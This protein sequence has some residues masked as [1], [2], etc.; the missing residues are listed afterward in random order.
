M[1][2]RLEEMSN[3]ELWRLFPII[4][5]PHNPLWRENYLRE[6]E[7]IEKAIGRDNI[8]RIHHYGST[9]IPGLLAK[10]TIDILLEVKDNT[11]LDKL[12]ANLQGAGYIYSPQPDNPP[13]G[14]MFLK[15]YTPEGFKG[16]VY[17]LH[18]RYAGDWDELY[19][20]DYLLAHPKAAQEYGQLKL[21]L[22]RKFEYDRDGYTMA[23]TEFIKKITQMAKISKKLRDL[24]QTINN[25]GQE[26]LLK[27]EEKIDFILQNGQEDKRRGLTLLIKVKNPVAEKIAYLM[28]KIRSIEGNQYFY[29]VSDLHVTVLTFLSGRENFILEEEIKRKS[30]QI[31][32]KAVLALPPFELEFRG[33][34]VTNAAILAKGYYKSGLSSLRDRIRELAIENDFPLRERY[35][36]ISGHST[37]VRFKNPLQKREKFLALIQEYQD[38]NLGVM[39]VDC[40]K[41]VVHDW[42][43]SQK[44][45]IRE[46]RLK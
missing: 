6:K 25:E 45:T 21:E 11:D 22:K 2:K 32:E 29:P 23:K 7:W 40:L 34:A 12:T 5:S 28:E 1:G 30:L 42:Y 31:V 39:E 19:F 43:N 17:H 10:P 35:Q 9:A 20:R 14:M 8:V 44:E 38:F 26:A 15:G 33:I 18:V 24:Y 41:L 27:G 4:I 37:I 13:P 3:E 36:T 46:F 16:E